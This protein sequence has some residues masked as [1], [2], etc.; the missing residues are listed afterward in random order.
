MGRRGGEKRLKSVN[1][2]KEMGRIKAKQRRKEKG[3]MELEKD[4]R[5]RKECKE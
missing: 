4:Q 5:K 3:W 1:V 2:G